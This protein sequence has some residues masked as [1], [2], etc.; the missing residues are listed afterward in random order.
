MK[1]HFQI[2]NSYKIWKPSKMKKAIIDK[3]A[4]SGNF[5]P[6]YIEWY[7]HNVVY[8]L[9]L[10]FVFIPAIKKLNRRAK[11]TDFIVEVAEKGDRKNV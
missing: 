11:D 4:Y 2:K 10:P 6:L 8:W 9:T 7:F 1:K 3:I 5:K